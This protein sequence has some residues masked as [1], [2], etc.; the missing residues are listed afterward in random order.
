MEVDKGEKLN[1]ILADELQGDNWIIIESTPK[2]LASK[3][4]VSR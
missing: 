2:I 4:K 1:H 3:G